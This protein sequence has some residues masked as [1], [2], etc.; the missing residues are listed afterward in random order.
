M[1]SF[2]SEVTKKKKTTFVNMTKT[3][4]RNPVS[5]RPLRC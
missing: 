5:W 1:T 3:P 4:L 2:R